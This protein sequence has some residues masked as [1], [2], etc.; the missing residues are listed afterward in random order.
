[1]LRAVGADLDTA[2]SDLERH[3][4]NPEKAAQEPLSTS[5]PVTWK[6]KGLG[7]TGKHIQ[8]PDDCELH[9]WQAHTDK[10]EYVNI[11]CLT[12]TQSR[13]H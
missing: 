7:H 10:H 11:K 3:F 13:V 2:S 12:D 6:G 1:M 4:M 5:S 8:V 9:A